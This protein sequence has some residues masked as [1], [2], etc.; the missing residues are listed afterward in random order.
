MSRIDSQMLKI[1]ESSSKISEKE[2]IDL[3]KR[4]EEINNT[5]SSSCFSSETSRK[6]NKKLLNLVRDNEGSFAPANREMIENYLKSGKVPRTVVTPSVA[7]NNHVVAGAVGSFS[8]RGAPAMGSP[9]PSIPASPGMVSGDTGVVGPRGKEILNF[10]SSKRTSEYHWFPIQETRPG[11]DPVNNL[12]A[13]G[14]PLDKLDKLNGGQARDYEYANNRKSVDDGKQFSWWGHCDKAATLACLLP[15]P[16]HRVT[17]TGQNGQSV[18]FSTNDIQGL[19]VKVAPTLSANV[20]FRGE[21]YNAS[22]RDDPS[23]PPP[24]VFME[25][26][27][28][29]AQD[30]M[31]F[32]LDIDRAEQVWNYPYDQAKIYESDKAPE[33]YNASGMPTDG[34]IKYYHIDM[35]GT[36]FDEKV[37]RY[38]CYVQKDSGGNVMNSEWIKTPNSHKNP[39]FMWRPKPVGDLMQKSAWQTRSANNPEVDPQMVYEIYMKSLA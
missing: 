20:D 28:E 35:A 39:D 25:V 5:A 21:R 2:T 16:K 31:P 22:V 13:V 34:T 12:Y 18:E 3:I 27:K 26:L 32:V 9:T 1:Y 23:D 7:H 11:G 8:R 37:R 29:W 38:E 36:G 24:H 17:M 19:L 14:G 33:G 30:G 4:A 15:A 6:G 10:V